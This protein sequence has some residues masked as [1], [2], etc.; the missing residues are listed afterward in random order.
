MC[1][2]LGAWHPEWRE[3]VLLLAGLLRQQ[4]AE[5]VDALVSESTKKRG[6]GAP[7]LV[8]SCNAVAS[9][10]WMVFWA[11]LLKKSYSEAQANPRSFYSEIV[12]RLWPAID[13]LGNKHPF[14]WRI[15]PMFPPEST[16]PGAFTWS[17]VQANWRLACWLIIFYGGCWSWH[18]A[19]LLRGLIHEVSME[20]KKEKIRRT[21][22]GE[23]PGADRSETTS[24]DVRAETIW[25]QAAETGKWW[26]VRGT[27]VGG[28]IGAV[29]AQA[30]NVW[31]GL[32]KP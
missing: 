18:S 19:T 20:E 13:W 25:V 2:R 15:A 16:G 27:I 14:I 3:V 32:V 4:R 6:G 23:R 5:R 1:S 26:S 21:R 24:I 8:G 7:V 9:S 10:A 12:R 29:L 17:C 22:R 31:L 11:G 30:I 28:C